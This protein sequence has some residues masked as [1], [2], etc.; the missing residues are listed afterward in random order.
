M[1]VLPIWLGDTFMRILFVDTYDVKVCPY[2]VAPQGA[3]G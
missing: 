1:L 2:N 3:A